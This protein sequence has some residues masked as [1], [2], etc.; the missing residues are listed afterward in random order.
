M[1]VNEFEGGEFRIEIGEGE[2][3]LGDLCAGGLVWC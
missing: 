2:S 1:C 3:R